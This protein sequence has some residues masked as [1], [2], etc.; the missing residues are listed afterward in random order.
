MKIHERLGLWYEKEKRDLPWRNSS[1][2]YKIWL[3]E[4][5]L[6]QTRVA[7]GTAYYH[8]FIE[9]FPDVFSLARAE[10]E[11]ILKIWQGL[12]YYSR[13]RNLHQ[14][15]KIVAFEL[16]GKFPSSFSGLIK[17]KGIGE[18]TAAAISSIAFNEPQAAIDGNVK[19]VV[20][21]LFSIE[22]EINS[23]A[24]KSQISQFASEIIDTLNPGRHNQA[25]MELGASICIPRKP[26]CLECPLNLNCLAL[27]EDKVSDLPLKYKKTKAVNRY[28]L[29]LII[30]NGDTIIVKQ[31]PSGDIW[32]GLFDFPLIETADSPEIG[33]FPNLIAKFLKV[34]INDFQIE[35]ISDIIIHKLSHRNLNTR[36]CHIHISGDKKVMPPMCKTI[37]INE[38]DTIPVP[39]LIDK[40][41]TKEGF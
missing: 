26:K 25:M 21:R 10:S 4:V 28:F 37:N 24:G 29:Y 11:E 13:A 2:P 19:R 15:A 31:R 5:I 9:K 32:E 1:D 3:S 36:F 34:S 16:G 40:Y 41:I 35:K 17:L 39:R 30:R 22:H 33:L 27:K 7:Q 23:L 12:G 6:Q 14:T 38:F 18:Y 8:R 20:S